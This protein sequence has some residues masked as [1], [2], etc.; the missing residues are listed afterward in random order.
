MNHR[1][2][3]AGYLVSI[4]AILAFIGLLAHP[5][6]AIWANGCLTPTGGIRRYGH[7]RRHRR[8]RALPGG[9]AAQVTVRLASAGPGLPEVSA[10]PAFPEASAA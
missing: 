9:L 2:G 10:A 4:L 3:Q 6:M 8:D 7:Y 1:R 5:H